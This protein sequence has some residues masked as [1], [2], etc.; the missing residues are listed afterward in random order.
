MTTYDNRVESDER[1]NPRP[2]QPRQKSVERSIFN[3]HFR[4]LGLVFAHYDVRF[5][6][7]RHN[8]CTSNYVFYPKRSEIANTLTPRQGDFGI[9]KFGWTG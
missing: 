4:K 1:H 5:V 6:G 2:T 7:S 9:P 8:F 3:I